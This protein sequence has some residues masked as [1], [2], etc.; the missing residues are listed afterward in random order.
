MEETRVD[1]SAEEMIRNELGPGEQLV[2]AGRPCLGLMLRA[3]DIFLI[4]FSIM[5]GGFAIFWETMVVLNGA[6][7]FFALWGVPFVLVGLYI[8]V[9][10][11]WVDARQRANTYYGVTS[12]RIVI[13][14]GLLSRSVKSLNIDTL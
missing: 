2:W 1:E 3:M 5:W 14:S 10:R 12:E 6:P 13:V 7:W 9:G 8:M 4:P 11:F